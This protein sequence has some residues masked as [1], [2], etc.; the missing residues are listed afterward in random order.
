MTHRP[1]A[2]RCS[3]ARRTTSWPGW[4]GDIS[5]YFPK[6]L[7]A[8]LVRAM[9]RQIRHKVMIGSNGLDLKRCVEELNELPLR[10]ASKERILR[11]NA[12]EFLGL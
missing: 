2:R 11:Q 3:P 12:I 4:Y 10:D 5:A 7:D 9:D 1:T 6:S 8:E